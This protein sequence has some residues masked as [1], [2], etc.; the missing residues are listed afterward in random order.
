MI[1]MLFPQSLQ[2]PGPDFGK[3]SKSLIS[4]ANL[5]IKTDALTS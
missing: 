1:K 3:I 4:H 5:I 2:G